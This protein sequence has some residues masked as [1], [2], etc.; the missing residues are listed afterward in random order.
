[1]K[2]LIEFLELLV[3]VIGIPFTVFVI[4]PFSLAWLVSRLVGG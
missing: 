4:V 2:D 3:M 1:M